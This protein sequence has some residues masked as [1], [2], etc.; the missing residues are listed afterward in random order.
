M[1]MSLPQRSRSDL[2]RAANSSFIDDERLLPVVLLLF[3]DPDPGEHQRPEM[4][5]DSICCG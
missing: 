1:L 3:V 4:P 2:S 5:F